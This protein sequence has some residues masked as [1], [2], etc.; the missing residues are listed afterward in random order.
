MKDKRTLPVTEHRYPGSE[1]IDSMSTLEMVRL[2]NRADGEVHLAVRETLPQIAEAIDQISTLMRR[3]GRLIYMGAGTSGR[4]GILD[5]SECPP[6]FNARLDQVIG[7]IAGGDKAIRNAV[8]QIEDDPQQGENDLLQI[9]LTPNDTVVGLA[10]SGRTPYVIGGL[11]YARSLGVL[12]VCICCDPNATLAEVAEIAI[13]PVVGPE[14]LTGSTRLK[15]GTAQKMV[16]NMLST[17]VMIRL[18]KTYGN[19]MVDLQANNTKLEA[20]SRRIIQEVCDV[21]AETAFDALQDCEGEVKTAIVMLIL[22]CTPK[23]ARQK[24]MDASGVVRSVLGNE[25]QDG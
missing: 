13:L 9:G 23:E 22:D 15:A 2:I 19:L 12:T 1:N 25:K 16:L 7:L 20:R 3:G 6:T 18:G 14:I 24:L 10:A 8:E 11:D 5:A 4:L 17:G 21:K